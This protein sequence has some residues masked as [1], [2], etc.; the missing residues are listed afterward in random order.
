M[1]NAASAEGTLETNGRAD[2]PS[3]QD[4]DAASVR[5]QGRLAGWRAGVPLEMVS[6]A[7]F[8]FLLG[9]VFSLLSNEFLTSSNMIGIASNSAAIGI[10][11][12]GQ[13]FVIIS[14]GFDLSVGGVI[15]LAT[16]V[17][18]LRVNHGTPFILALIEVLLCGAAFGVGNGL[19]V[20]K[21]R[22]SPLIT[23]LATTSIAGGLAF[24]ISS[25]LSVP[26][27]N[28]HDG[29]LAD[30]GPLQIPNQVTIFAAVVVIGFVCLRYTSY[31]RSVYAVGG[32]SEA[33]RLAGMR[34]DALL[35]SVYAFSGVLA[36]LGGVVLSSQLLSG[37][38][39]IGTD[40]ALTS[41]TAVVLGGAALAG[42]VGSVW[43]TLLG[44]L[45]LGVLSNGLAIL[46]VSSFYQTIATGVVLLI[47]V[48]LGRLTSQSSRR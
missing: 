7:L 47:A 20:A 46:H 41:I 31:G 4:E 30:R 25:G 33:S 44:V 43:G 45:I 37:S 35:V 22:I 11:C 36:A 19:I 10:V 48:G 15:P 26:Y 16:V 42:G 18:A 40:S 14:G 34:V 17:F 32:N 12:I 1:T 13:T 23:T 24:S 21:G 8:L 6:L 2:V 29:V 3:G 38:G 5:R 27:N 9:L 28:V 39:T